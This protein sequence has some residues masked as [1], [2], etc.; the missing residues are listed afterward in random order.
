M[1]TFREYV[2]EMKLAFKRKSAKPA[3][4]QQ[5]KEWNREDDRLKIAGK[6]IKAADELANSRDDEARS[7]ANRARDRSVFYKKD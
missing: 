3:K 2:I 5:E 7:R 6:R 1:K 4:T